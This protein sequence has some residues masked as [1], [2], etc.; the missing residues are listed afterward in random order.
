MSKF[1][2]LV[3]FF[4]L[5]IALVAL[6]VGVLGVPRASAQ[7][8][9]LKIGVIGGIDS[10][11]LRGVTLAAE[12]ANQ[13]GGVRLPDG[14]QVTVSVVAVDAA[15]PEEVAAAIGQL[16]QTG[17]FALFGPDDN[18]LAARSLGTI[19]VA[20]IPVFTAA[21]SSDVRPGGFVFR[22]QASDD[23]RMRALSDV[24]TTDLG[25]RT[26]NIYQGNEDAGS[27]TRALVMALAQRG[28][29]ATPILQDP[30]RP[31]NEAASVMLQ[32]SPDT[33]VAFGSPVQVAE[34]YEA[35]KAAG[36][37]GRFVTSVADDR[38][39]VTSITAAPR[40]GII[41]V[42]GWTF[43][44]QTVEGQAFT[45]DFLLV[46]G[47]APTARDAAAFDAAVN[48]LQI[49]GRTGPAPA[50]LL[51]ALLTQAPVN[52]VQGVFNPQLGGGET[53]NNV[54]IFETSTAGAPRIIA[55]FEG[56]Q[57][58]ARDVVAPTAVPPQVAPTLA[59]PPT[60]APTVAPAGSPIP[61]GVSALVITDFVNVRFGPGTIYQPPIGRLNRDMRVSL[62]GANSNYTWFTF[63]YNGQLA[64]ISGD[65]TLIS[66]TGDPR[67]L[68]IVPAPPTPTPAVT[69]TPTLLPG[70]VEADIVV[71]NWFLNPNPIK[72][73]QP[74]SL[75]VTIRNQG[76]T[77]AGSFAVAAS[78]DPGGVFGA[79][80]QPGLAPG[81]Q[82]TLTINYPGVTGGGT[83]KVAIVL[84]LNKEVNEGAA[85][86]SNNIYEITYQV[87]Q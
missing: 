40:A 24:L 51:A 61:P 37:N 11:T 7:D 87:V 3:R 47:E 71:L 59:L 16:R 26:I 50:A 55:R 36:F 15:T 32:N 76:Q 33:L 29:G 12:L 54:V 42:T 25:A 63:N 34:L 31:V 62:L 21:T 77:A 66:I 14:R 28:V 9:Q 19:A 80:I 85:G 78:F 17:I 58:L 22:T 86:E 60:L 75:S 83:F 52:S 74:F 18:G 6:L 56:D 2:K 5:G 81:Q 41:G 67:T 82:N 46:F 49:V 35:V 65:P 27:P 48:L 23:V 57:R 53:T 44:T 4:V 39:F 64:W 43:A 30:N 69:A 38:A 45:R 73:G 72:S 84:D 70:P 1:F 13:G 20:G 8:N 79:A 10:P 68:P